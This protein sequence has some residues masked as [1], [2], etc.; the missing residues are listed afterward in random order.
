MAIHSDL[1]LSRL[2]I[3]VWVI[4]FHAP[5]MPQRFDYE[6]YCTGQTDY[7]CHDPKFICAVP[8]KD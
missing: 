7:L 8:Q 6:A 2:T 4:S 3:F 1:S 5:E